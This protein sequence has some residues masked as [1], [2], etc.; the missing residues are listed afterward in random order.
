MADATH[1]AED[2][3]AGRPV[4]FRNATVITVD[5][6]GVI[7]ERR[8]ARHRRHDRRA[9]GPK[10]KVPEGTARDRRDAAAS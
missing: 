3:A 10:L 4:V 2:F 1:R 5:K 9:V 7:L 8:R 6:A